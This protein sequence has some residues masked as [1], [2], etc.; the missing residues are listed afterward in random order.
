MK[1]DY[2]ILWLDDKMDEILSDDYPK[3]IKTY[4]NEQGFEPKII[5]VKNEKDFFENLNDTFDLILTDFHLNETIDNTRNGDAII[6]EVRNK[7]IFTEIMF[8]SAQG[9]VADTIKKDRITF[10]DTRKVTGNIHYEKIVEKVIYLIGLTIKK[11]QH[12][13]AMRGMIM[14]ETC[15]LDIHML[16]IIKQALKMKEINFDDLAPNIY[17]DLNELYNSK[18][19][20]VNECRDNGKFTTLTKDN[21]VFSA[22]YKIK[23]LGQ[24]LKCLKIKD[25]SDEY[26][27][28]INSMRNKFAH[29]TLLK[30]ETT[31]REY[32]KHGES[33]L[34]FDDELCKKIRKDIIKHRDNFNEIYT[35]VILAQ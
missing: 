22:E 16:E 25:F 3:D 10:F 8:Y 28:E 5:T 31:G 24:I 33:G 20:F 30:D 18:N 26:K 11:F 2:K 21:F 17:D 12:I 34:T 9:D 13:V 1:L 32:F 6:E 7:S 4:L 15:S 27:E 29:S 19:K 23:T 14:N 35:K